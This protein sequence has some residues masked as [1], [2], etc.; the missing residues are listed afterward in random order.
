MSEITSE[1]FELEISEEGIIS[2]YRYS[3]HYMIDARAKM[4]TDHET[5][6]YCEIY[7]HITPGFEREV[8]QDVISEM[9]ILY[10]KM[11]AGEL[12]IDPEYIHSIK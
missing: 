4:G 7:A 2:N 9:H 3:F 5:G 8:P 10:G 11:L 12:G 6:E 1:Y